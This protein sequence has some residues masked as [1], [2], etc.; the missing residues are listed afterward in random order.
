MSNEILQLNDT[1]K[2]LEKG[3]GNTAINQLNAFINSIEAQ[4]DKELT[5]DEADELIEAALLISSSI[6]NS[7]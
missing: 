1:I 2:S 6:L 5:D 7:A 3:Q 4:R